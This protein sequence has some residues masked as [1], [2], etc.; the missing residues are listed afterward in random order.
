M[1]FEEFG[2]RDPADIEARVAA[3]VEFGA[4]EVG[5]GVVAGEVEGR[6]ALEGAVG[7]GGAEVGEVVDGFD[8][9]AVGALGV[10]EADLALEFDQG[11]IN[12]VLEQGGAGGCGA[13]GEVAGVDDGAVDAGV[14]HTAGGEGAGDAGAD[15]DG[16]AASV[17]FEGGHYVHKAVPERPEGMFGAEV[18]RRPFVLLESLPANMT[19]PFQPD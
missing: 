12:V 8:A 9:R 19:R 13:L 18:Q 5:V 4:E 10:C 3:G 6:A 15:D 11:D 16:V 7:E 17:S 1:G 14:R 2:A